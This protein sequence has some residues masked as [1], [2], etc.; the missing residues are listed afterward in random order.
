MNCLFVEQPVP[1]RS[2]LLVLAVV[3]VDFAFYLKTQTSNNSFIV[4]I[5]K[6]IHTRT[7]TDIRN[8]PQNQ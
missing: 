4:I 7:K 5:F 1:L 2:L 3:L 6:Y 8:N